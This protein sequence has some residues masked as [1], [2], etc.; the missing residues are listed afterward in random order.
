M[1]VL[2]LKNVETEGPGTVEE[3]LKASGLHY[4]ILEPGDVP[5]SALDGAGALVV[6]GGPMGVYEAEEYPHMGAAMKLM[7]EALKK[8][9][10]LLGICLGAQMLAHVLGAKVYKGAQGQEIGWY[11]ITLTPEG[12]NDPALAA[13]AGGGGGARVF[14][15]HGDTFD[16]PGGAVRLAGSSMYDAQAFRYGTR[17]YGLQFHLEVTEGMVADWMRDIPGGERLMSEDAPGRGAY[18][19]AAERFYAVMFGNVK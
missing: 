19:S 15:W 5:S 4:S 13:Y 9:I 18:D 8:D 1:S 2:I 17:A 7:G 10:P 14:H 16:I 6:L 12:M 11:D 3:Y